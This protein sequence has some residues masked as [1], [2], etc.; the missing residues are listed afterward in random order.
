MAGDI[1][2]TVAASPSLTSVAVLA[3]IVL[4][5][6]FLALSLKVET[7]GRWPWQKRDNAAPFNQEWPSVDTGTASPAMANGGGRP[8]DQARTQRRSRGQRCL[9]VAEGRDAS[10]RTY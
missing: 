10:C 8:D 9:D 7:T 5:R 3:A 1:V 4:I 6:T 2:R